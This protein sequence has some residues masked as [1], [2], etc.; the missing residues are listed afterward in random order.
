MEKLAESATTENYEGEIETENT[1]VYKEDYNIGDIV[2][3]ENEY[4]MQASTRV[5]EIIESDNENGYRAVPTFGTW[6]V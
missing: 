2:E 4:K 6:E 3:V 1:Y 5:T